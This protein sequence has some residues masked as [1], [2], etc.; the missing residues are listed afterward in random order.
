VILVD[1]NILVYA[2]APRM[3][4]HAAANAWLEDQLGSGR[5]TALPWPVLLAFVRLVTHPGL[6]DPAL[7]VDDA[8]TV[9]HG[10]LDC[11]GVWVPAAGADHARRL[12]ELLASSGKA[13]N[14]VYDAHLAA[15][16]LEHGL[17]VCSC[18]TDFARFPGVR[19]IDPLRPG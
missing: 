15:L 7:S 9:V 2:V 13:G 6:F 11:P 3:P 5:R 10:W 14:L 12:H 4:Q 17:T 16:A 19:W 1:A 18:D 8:M